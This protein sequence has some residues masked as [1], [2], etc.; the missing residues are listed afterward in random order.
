[1]NTIENTKY[2]KKF[3]ELFNTLSSNFSETDLELFKEAYKTS[4]KAY[5]Q[6]NSKTSGDKIYKSLEVTKIVVLEME[7]DKCSIFAAL[8][9]DSV[10]TGYT[11]IEEIETKFGSQISSLIAGLQKIASIN[12]DKIKLQADNFRNLLLSITDDV[13]VIF[14]KLANR[15]HQIRDIDKLHIDDRL[16]KANET[17]YLYAP[18]AHRL[19]LYKIKT[20]MEDASMKF[21]H[22][23]EY[24]EIAESLQQSKDKRDKYIKDFITPIKKQLKSLGYKSE[25]KE[26]QNRYILY[27]IR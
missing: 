16:Q 8:L 5:E 18:I 20:D 4:L 23:K 6:H 7:L 17:Y 14:I 27:G 11:T 15:L 19:G 1:M 12:T 10:K 21:M 2:Y 25:I 24:K 13:R 26:D 9:Q 22:Y 3:L